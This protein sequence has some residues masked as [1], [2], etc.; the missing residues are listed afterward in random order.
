MELG[1]K[2]LHKEIFPAG[3]EIFSA[4]SKGDRA[5]VIETGKVAIWHTINGQRHTLG[6]IADGSIFGEMAL[7]DN[8]PR[9]ASASAVTETT[10]VVIGEEVFKN[11]LIEADPFLVGLIRIFM[12][13][14]RSLTENSNK[15]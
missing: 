3:T 4:G 13:N 12:S 7:I 9:M 1:L 5:Y 2:A 15:K 14:I 6:V 10:C 11:K 8:Q